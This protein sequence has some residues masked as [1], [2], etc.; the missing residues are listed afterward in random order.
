LVL[1]DF[2]HARI[3]VELDLGQAIVPPFT[4]H[5]FERRVAS[6]PYSSAI[7]RNLDRLGVQAVETPAAWRASSSISWRRI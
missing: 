4:A 6:K 1:D 3:F 2:D 5:N 7:C